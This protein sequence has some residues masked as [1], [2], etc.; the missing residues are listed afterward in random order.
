MPATLKTHS[1]RVILAGV[2]E[3]SDAITDAAPMMPGVTTRAWGVA[4]GT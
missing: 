3:I 2:T 1:F 4:T